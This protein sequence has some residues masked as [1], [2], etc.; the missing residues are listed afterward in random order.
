MGQAQILRY[1]RKE[2]VIILGRTLMMNKPFS[3]ERIY[4]KRIHKNAEI[5]VMNLI[6]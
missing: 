4:I 2:I 1:S 3:R 5:N 6:N